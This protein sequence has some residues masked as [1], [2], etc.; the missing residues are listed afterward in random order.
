LTI[1]RLRLQLLAQRGERDVQS[2]ATGARLALGPKQLD[3]LLALMGAMGVESQIGEQRS[4][5]L[6]PEPLDTP[7]TPGCPQMTQELDAPSA[8]QGFS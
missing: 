3:Q 8:F 1:N 2:L 7:V 6:R 5:L 4:G